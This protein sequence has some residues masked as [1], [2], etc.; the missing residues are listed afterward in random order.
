MIE[1]NTIK[2]E[3]GW[4]NETLIGE[5]AIDH[6][7]RIVHIYT[8]GM[9]NHKLGPDVDFET[10]RISFSSSFYSYVDK[11]FDPDGYYNGLNKHTPRLKKILRELSWLSGSIPEE[12]QENFFLKRIRPLQIDVW[13]ESWT[14][15]FYSGGGAIYVYHNGVFSKIFVLRLFDQAQYLLDLLYDPFKN[16]QIEIQ[17]GYMRGEFES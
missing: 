5:M 4:S 8:N 10:N 13:I 14:W 1:E 16:R 11:T 2:L 9:F 6:E 3:D 17:K 7:R 15:C 12:E